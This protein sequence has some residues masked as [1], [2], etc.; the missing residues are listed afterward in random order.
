MNM[1]RYIENWFIHHPPFGNQVERYQIIRDAGK[2]LAEC[3]FVNCP[4]SVERDRAMMKI[5]EAIMLANASIACNE[6]NNT[7]TKDE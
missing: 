4:D 1:P 5:R 6:V 7:Q 3:L 2:Q